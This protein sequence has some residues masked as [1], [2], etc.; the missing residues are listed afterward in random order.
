[1]SGPHR[2]VTIQDVTGRDGLQNVKRWIPTHVK[3]DL[4]RAS[5]DAG[6]PWLEVTSF[7][8]PRWVPQL[9]D[10]EKVVDAL[11]TVPSGR[12]APVLSALVP[13]VRGVARAAGRGLDAVS[14]TTSASEAHARSNLARGRDEAIDAAGSVAAAAREAGVTLRGGIATAFG[15]PVQGDVPLADVAWIVQRYVALGI[16][17]IRLGDTTGMANPRSIREAVRA[18]RSDHPD[19]TFV[20]HLHDTRGMG[21]ANAIAGVEE[22]VTHLDAAV[23]GLGGCPFAPGASGN[24]DLVDLVHA[25]HEMGYRTGIDLD[26]V[27]ALARSLERRTGLEADGRVRVA[28]TRSD[29]S[30]GSSRPSEPRPSGR[31]AHGG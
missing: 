11:R 24:V 12:P 5:I 10:A 27:L 18:L 26:A 15:C 3:V 7:V 9:A 14:L 6:V 13:N 1:M 28:G 29:L 21:I 22:G 30:P 2:D 20:L 8:H 23:G 31:D 16:D 19:V 25:L 4:L 17:T